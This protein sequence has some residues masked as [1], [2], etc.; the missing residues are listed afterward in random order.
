[1]VVLISAAERGF[2]SLVDQISFPRCDTGFSETHL[3]Q[4]WTAPVPPTILVLL[5]YQV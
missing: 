3:N 4:R 5:S 2:E 1:M